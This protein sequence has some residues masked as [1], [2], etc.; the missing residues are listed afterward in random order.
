MPMA[1]PGARRRRF[2]TSADW[3][4]CPSRTDEPAAPISEASPAGPL[5][6][7]RINAV[8]ITLLEGPKWS[9][10]RAPVQ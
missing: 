5:V 7:P 9:A 4:A 10:A 3:S 1:R 2:G 6:A 8:T